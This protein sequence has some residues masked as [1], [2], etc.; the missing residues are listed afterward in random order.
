M[1][2]VACPK[3]GKTGACDDRLRSRR[4]LCPACRHAFM[5]RDTSSAQL[6]G[7]GQSDSQQH[8]AHS[9]LAGM[10]ADVEAKV[11]AVVHPLSLQFADPVKILELGPNAI[12]A[13]QHWLQNPYVD[14]GGG[15]KGIV[16]QAILVVALTHFAEGRGGVNPYNLPQ[17][18]AMQRQARSIVEAVAQ[19]KVPVAQGMD[20]DTTVAVAQQWLSEN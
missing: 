17:G 19:G 6:S 1:I 14:I 11:L 7:R 10:L 18:G 13:C 5:P 16:K 3:C 9:D 15:N 2:R 8:A 20:G 4:I 12:Y